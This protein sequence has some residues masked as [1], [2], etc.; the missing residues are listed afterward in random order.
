MFEAILMD[1]HGLNGWHLAK[2][3]ESEI[4]CKCVRVYLARDSIAYAL[5]LWFRHN[6][7]S[8]QLKSS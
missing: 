6:R 2:M 3:P 4:V 7:R 8:M 5:F 1:F